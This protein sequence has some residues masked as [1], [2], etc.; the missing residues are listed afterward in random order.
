MEGCLYSAGGYTTLL[1]LATRLI[2]E[3]TLEAENRVVLGHEL[4]S[5]AH[6]LARAQG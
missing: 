1:K 2:V 6:P 4:L 3:E 5:T